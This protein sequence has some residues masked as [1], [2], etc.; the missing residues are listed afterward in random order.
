MTSETSRQE[1]QMALEIL[2]SLPN[3][4]TLY[5]E[6]SDL[7]GDEVTMQV[8]FDAMAELLDEMVEE[9]DLTTAKAYLN[10]VDSLL[11]EKFNLY[12]EIIYCFIANLNC[13]DEEYF[14]SL[15]PPALTAACLDEG[16][17]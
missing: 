1:N 5:D 4:A 3:F 6:L 7:Y 17:I 11:E 10:T 16:Y 8:I 14:A 15:L 2:F 13:L 9:G 12:E